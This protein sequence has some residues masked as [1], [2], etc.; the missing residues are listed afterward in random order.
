[1]STSPRTQVAVRVERRPEPGRPVL[2]FAVEDDLQVHG[3]GDA[4]CGERVDGGEQRDDGRLVVGRRARVDPPVVLVG[5]AGGRERAQP[6]RPSRC[7]RPESGFEGPGAGPRRR[8]HR[9]AV[10]MRVEHHRARGAGAGSSASTIGPRF[11]ISKNCTRNPRRSSMALSRSAFRRMFG[12]SDAML[13]IASRST[14]SADDGAAR[15]LRGTRA[16]P[17]RRRR[18][19]AEP[20]PLRDLLSPRTRAAR[21]TADAGQ[22]SWCQAIALSHPWAASRAAATASRPAR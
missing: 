11:G 10:V 5:R 18:E 8:I 22:C 20:A 1:M 12:S 13:G 3:A 16:P 19:Q 21:S 15:A 6:S 2:L 9:L 17:S 14:S 7:C 4:L